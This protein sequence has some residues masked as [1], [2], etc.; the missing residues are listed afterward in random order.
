ML[1]G[2]EE[3]AM[4]MKRSLYGSAPPVHPGSRPPAL[5]PEHIAILRDIVTDRPG[6]DGGSNS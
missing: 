5:K 6:F 1:Q 4:A 3:H 2:M